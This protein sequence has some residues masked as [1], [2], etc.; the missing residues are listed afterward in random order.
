MSEIFNKIISFS[1]TIDRKTYWI[2]VIPMWIVNL[3]SLDN[4]RFTHIYGG[5]LPGLI[6]GLFMGEWVQN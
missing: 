6:K 1:G 4:A 5:L 3:L 2:I